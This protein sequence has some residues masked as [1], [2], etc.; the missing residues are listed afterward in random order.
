MTDMQQNFVLFWIATNS[1]LES[2]SQF[3][4]LELNVNEIYVKNVLNSFYL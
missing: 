3:K 2:L 4:H 1:L